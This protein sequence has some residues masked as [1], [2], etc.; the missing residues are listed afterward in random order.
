MEQMEN[1]DVLLF[2]K[3]VWFSS[4]SRFANYN[5]TDKFVGQESKFKQIHFQRGCNTKS[6]FCLT[7][8]IL[9][10]VATA[11]ALHQ[12]KQTTQVPPN[13]DL[14]PKPTVAMKKSIEDR[15]R[16]NFL[17]SYKFCRKRQSCIF[18]TTLMTKTEKDDNTSE[19]QE[20][21]VRRPI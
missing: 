7:F 10:T 21:I 16:S 12:K 8:S 18:S 13:L 14:S 5:L 20:T 17:M 6:P 4:Y 3:N 2:V 19:E 1:E 11:L 15:D 9:F